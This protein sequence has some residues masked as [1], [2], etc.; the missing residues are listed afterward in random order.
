MADKKNVTQDGM[1]DKELNLDEMEKAS[2]G[3]ALEDETVKTK[4]H[5]L[6][7]DTKKQV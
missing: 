2:G 4:T 3:S 7:D 1:K 6:T 5:D